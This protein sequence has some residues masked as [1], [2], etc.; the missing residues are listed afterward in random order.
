MYNGECI[1]NHSDYVCFSFQAIKHLTTVDGGAIACRDAEDA[2]RARLMRWL[3]LDRSAGASMRCVQDPPEFGYKA[4]LSDVLSSIGLANLGYLQD[5]IDK[6]NMNAA[7]YDRAF[8]GLSNVTIAHKQY[9]VAPNY[10]L[11]TIHVED[12][13]K[14]IDYM[15]KN[16]VETSKVHARNDTKTIFAESFGTRL[17]GVDSFD[18]THVCIPVGCWL[19]DSDVDKIV[20]LVRKYN[21]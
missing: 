17:P 14:F 7:K 13:S 19:S 10:W 1:G 9:G 5:I 21:G 20:D 16:G 15:K 4:Q 2:K 3:G 18:K 11:Y 6:T 12:S 8:G